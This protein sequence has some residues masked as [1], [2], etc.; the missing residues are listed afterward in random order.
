MNGFTDKGK[1][2][3]NSCW[4]RFLNESFKF[5]AVFKDARFRLGLQLRAA[6]VHQSEAA[7]QKI[8]ELHPRAQAPF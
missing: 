1:R 5:T 6:G 2:N 4:S 8:A 3:L 7:R